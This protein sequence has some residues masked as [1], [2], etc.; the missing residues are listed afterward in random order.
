M[1]IEELKPALSV[2]EQIKL[3]NS[4]GLIIKDIEF[5][6]QVLSKISY[7]RLSGYW[8]SFLRKD[9]K[10]EHFAGNISFEDIYHI[11]RF[12]QKLRHIIFEVIEEIEITFRTK[13]VNYFACTYGPLKYKEPEYFENAEYHKEFLNEI[14]KAIKEQENKEQFVRH[15]LNKYSGEFPIWVVAEILSFGSMS[16]FY[17]NLKKDDRDKISKEWTGFPSEYLKSWLKSLV[18]VRNLC[19]HYRRLYRQTFA[20]PPKLS[21][22][23]RTTIGN[24]NSLFAIC[25]VMKYMLES[26]TWENFITNLEALFEEYEEK[27]VDI[28]LI[29]FPNNWLKIFRSSI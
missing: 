6:M 20:F 12:D 21:K 25:F 9:N 26:S 27:K 3:L 15:Y 5:A 8:H 23:Q 1:S 22:K 28:S 18:L 19:A 11:Y 7:Y 16:K 17:S 4:K 13:V 24:N 2:E 10:F 29:G 14:E